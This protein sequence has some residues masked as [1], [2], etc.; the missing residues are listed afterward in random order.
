MWNLHAGQGATVKTG[1]GTTN[2]F[3]TGKGV[4]Q[5]CILSLCLFTLCVEYITH[6]GKCWIGWIT[7]WNQDC[8]EKYHQLQICRWYHSNSRKRKVT[9]E[10]LDEDE[11]GQ[12]QIDLKL[13]I[14][15]TK[16]MVSGPMTSWQRDW[17][18]VETVADFIFLSSKNHCGLWLQPWKWKTLAPWKK[19]YD[20]P[21]Q[22]I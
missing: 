3:K 4:C 16:I 12:W 18:K 10:P 11:G 20:K 9:K 21:R 19:I 1:H 14:Q 5:G 22:C 8:Q 2:W 13:N 17:E 15:K 7:S 6:H